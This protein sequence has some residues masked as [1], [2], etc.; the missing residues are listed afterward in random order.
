MGS[1]LMKPKQNKIF[2]IYGN[3][4][5]MFITRNLQRCNFRPFLNGYLKSIGYEQVVFYSGA[6]NVGKFV[7]D[8]ESAI[9]AINKNKGF[10]KDGNGTTSK[11]APTEKKRR[12]ILNP[13][14]AEA[15]KT[16]TGE[17]DAAGTESQSTNAEQGNQSGKLVYKQPKITPVEFL[18]DAKKMMADGEHKSAVVFTFFQDFF[19]D[20]AAPLQPY[21]ELVSH[22]W[23]EYSSDV[24]E[25]I[26][27]F[28]APQMS[29]ADLNKMFDNMEN[30][31]VLKNRFFNENGTV[32]RR[33][34]IEVGLPNP[35]EIGYMLDYLRIIGVKGKKIKY[36]QSEKKRLISSIMYLSRESERDENRSGYLYAIYNTFIDYITASDESEVVI[37]EDV[38]KGLYSRYQKV[39]ES[40]PFDKLKNTRGWESVATRIEEILK[41]FRMKKAAAEQKEMKPTSQKVEKPAC[42]NERIDSEVENSGYRYPV[43]HFIL[44]GNPGVGKTT[45]ARL[46]GQIFYNEG[47]LLKGNTIEA[48]RDDLVDQYVGGTA[49]KTTE[50]VERAQEG[51]LF[52]DDA[53]SLLDKGDEHNYPKEAIDTLVPIMTNPDKYRF[54]MIMAG[55]PEPMDELLE[56]NSGLR[57]RFSKANILTIED[58]KPDLLQEI[59]VGS[60]RK[61]GYRFIGDEEGEESLDL[62]LF[63]TN[64]YNQRNRADFGNARDIVA[65]A[66]EVK[67]QCSLRDDVLRRIEKED[68]GDSQKYF[69]KRGVSSIDEIY[70][71]IDNY[72]G[73]D[74]VKVLFK[75]I[76][77][78]VLDTIDS[79]KRGIK[80]EQYPDHYIFA[81]NP[82]TG[83]T[84]VG[85]MIGELYHMMEVLGG[86]ETLFV[87]A[88]DIIGNH[89][90]DSKNKIVE[91]MQ[92]A[93]DHNQ[94][95]Y[96]DEAYQISESA[97]GNE[98]IGAMMTKMTENADDFKVIF[99]MYS[100]K[101]EDFLKMNAGLSRRLRI[102]QFPDYTPDQLLE[103]FDRTIKSQ[104]CTIA[105]DAHERVR[106]ILTHKYN[107]RG[108]DFGNAGEVKKMVIDMKRLR[109]ERTYGSDDPD[110][111]KYEYTLD[112]IPKNLLDTVEDQVNPKSLEDIMEELNR[113]IGMSDLKD[114]IVQKQEEMIFAQKSG[115]STDN[116]RPGYYFFVG[117]PGT[118]KSTSAKLF[119]E[120][121]HRLGIVKTN[122]FHSCTAK[123]LIGQYVGETDK[124]TYA[125]LQKSINSVL[126]IDEAYSLSYADSRSD[127]NYKKEALEQIIAFMDEPEHRRSCCIILAGYEKDMQG[128]Y[129][130]NSGMRSRIEE[131]HFKDYSAKET[132]D[133][134]ALFC[135]KNGFTIADGVEEIYIP[136]FDELKKLE[137]FSNGRTAR[138]IFEKTTM[139]L[140]R[141]VVRSSDITG[142]SAKHIIPEDLLSV[143]EAIRVIGVDGK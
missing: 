124:K 32:N 84:T 139:N 63:F 39:D 69:I 9:M 1:V 94:V 60:C 68:F 104:G 65:L 142:D 25:N 15:A 122:N 48:K 54:C 24:N 45:V 4:D 79:K 44:R 102:V 11:P 108:E 30:G 143:R 61:D 64:L 121:L 56:M 19:T 17:S 29:C 73:M 88:S 67:M 62:D 7:L 93:I 99:G 134:F 100:N 52:I 95:L 125:L 81:G 135:T 87:D 72:V 3:L 96:I 13:R 53:Y 86:A 140:K 38:V 50:C 80:P 59:F 26:C 8:D 103:I 40:D 55:Y 129:K 127:T 42:S 51:V 120:C 97:Y 35:D 12:R 85:K 113:Q 136:L 115:E 141:R 123:D 16:E 27:I 76:R 92:K 118:G 91:I 106:L 28:L 131:V 116:I 107:V 114:I 33:T 128:L 110:I 10:R 89:V 74:F 34:T 112:D 41:D 77:Y 43:P 21:L 23:D 126:F 37:D 31:F 18:D 22:L 14:A 6:K 90:G 137:Y 130:S 36:R 83:K 2:L 133:I 66:K 46:I 58:Y 117:N 75:N 132:Y 138:T 49:I 98:I 119:A 78:E 70:E 47:I 71:Q 57:S 109:L 101:V 111:N 82:G 5:D 20:R 105:E